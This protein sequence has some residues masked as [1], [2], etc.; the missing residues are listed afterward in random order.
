VS[1]ATRGES[2]ERA[3]CAGHEGSGGLVQH[4]RRNTKPTT[5]DSPTTSTTTTSTTTTLAPAANG[6]AGYWKLDEG[7]GA[8]TADELGGYATLNG[9]TLPAWQSAADS[10]IGPSSLSFDTGDRQ[11]S[12]VESTSY[13]PAQSVTQAAMTAW[14]YWSGSYNGGGS[15]QPVMNLTATD[16]KCLRLVFGINNQTTTGGGNIGCLRVQAANSSD[17]SSADTNYRAY[18]YDSAVPSNTWLH[19]AA[20]VDWTAN[21]MQIFVNGTNRTLTATTRSSA[22]GSRTGCNRGCN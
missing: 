1:G 4:R 12:R 10:R 11:N 17:G 9:A 15:Y 3:L 2:D 20:T 22:R 5:T 14:I 13:G 16:A 6:L 21:T 19:V 18:Y 7:S 8:A